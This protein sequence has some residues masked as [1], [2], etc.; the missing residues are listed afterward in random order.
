MRIKFLSRRFYYS[1]V[2][3]LFSFTLWG[4]LAALAGFAPN[5]L[6]KISEYFSIFRS[7]IFLL[8]WSLTSNG[9]ILSGSNLVKESCSTTSL[10]LLGFVFVVVFTPISAAYSLLFFR[11]FKF[12]DNE[13]ELW[14][15][16]LLLLIYFLIIVATTFDGDVYL[17]RD[18]DFTG[19]YRPGSG[20]FVISILYGLFPTV[21]GTVLAKIRII[22]NDAN[23]V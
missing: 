12:S 23:R 21:V 11:N 14:R 13:T 22:L 15:P 9:E 3:E 16:L 17:Y 5:E 7:Y 1:N 6:C 8:D 18:G 19:I 20:Y 4:G 2:F 10:I